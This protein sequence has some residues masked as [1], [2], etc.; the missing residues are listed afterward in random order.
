MKNLS[1]LK[2]LLS[3]PKKVVIVTHF[4]PDADALGSSLGLA[5][6]L[7]KKGHRVEVVTP[8]DFPEFL[9]WMPGSE[10]VIAL[11]RN[12]REPE[13]KSAALISAADIIFCL[14]FSNLARINEL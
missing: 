9:A 8:S 4:K 10:A 3:S 13:Q 12:S 14:D 5:G 2:S 11:S 7:R 1:D 6:F